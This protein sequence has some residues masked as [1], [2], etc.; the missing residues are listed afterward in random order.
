MKKIQIKDMSDVCEE[1]HEL[2]ERECKRQGYEVDCT[3]IYNCDNHNP[4][5]HY[6][7]QAQDIFNNYYDNLIEKYDI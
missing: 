4:E 1:A 2:T 5:A 3:S 7:R 6:S